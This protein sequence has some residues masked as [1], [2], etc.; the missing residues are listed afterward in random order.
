MFAA[1]CRL[2]TGLRLVLVS[3]LCGWLLVGPTQAKPKA[4][5]LD[6]G[7]DNCHQLVPPA[8]E[9]RNLQALAAR[10]GP[11]LFYAGSK[12]RPEWLRVWLRNPQRIRPAGLHPDRNTRS[13]DGQDELDTSR[14]EP[15]PVVPAA[16]LEALVDA[17]VALDWQ[18]ERLPDEV[19]LKPVPAMLAR[20][21]FVKF[22]GCA[23]CHRSCEDFGGASGPEL[24]TAWKRLRPEFLWSYIADPQAWDPVAP[25]PG[26]AL[27]P[28]E[29]GKL[30][31][32]LRQLS[33]ED[34]AAG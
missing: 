14:L 3:V 6:A 17:L 22:K 15:H 23:S 9:A 32:Y 33:E 24:Y 7:C 18:S 2:S 1:F 8:P 25:M 28:A 26:Y 4:P 20:M 10:K 16:K 5:L 13:V 29:V 27:V 21:N 31:D 34:H 12:F 11:D 30:V 19:Q